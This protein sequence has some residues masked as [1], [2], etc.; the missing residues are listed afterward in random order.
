VHLKESTGVGG[1]AP[2]LD[3]VR[4]AVWAVL[5]ADDAR[6]VSRKLW[7]LS[8]RCSGFGLTVSEKKTETLVMCVK[9][10]KQS[11]PPPPAPP[12][13]I[14]A[15]GQRCAQTTEFPNL[16]GLAN[17]HGDLTREINYRI[18]AVWACF[19]RHV[20]EL[21]DRP[22]A[23]V[24]LEIRLPQAEAME[25][26]LYGCMTRAPRNEHHRLMRTTHYRLLLRVI[27]YRRQRGTYRQLSCAQALKRVGCQSVETTVRQR[28]L[29]FAGTLARQ[30]DGPLP[31]RLM[32]RELEGGEKPGRECPEQNLDK[33][34]ADDFKAFVGDTRLY[35]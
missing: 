12:L 32:I 18:K 2:P 5:Y 1:S 29:P 3:R 14:E 15:A 17:E 25:A 13:V 31:K 20:R 30:P 11:Q 16:G 10:E 24:R 33:R 28:R 34:L 26:L 7:P 6:V 22:R 19:R 8:W 23:P 21:F 4:R 9:E 27:G 35:E